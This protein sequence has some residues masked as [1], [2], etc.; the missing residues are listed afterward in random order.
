MAA[1]PSESFVWNF[2]APEGWEVVA[3]WGDGFGLRQKNGGLRVLVD[4][5]LKSD[6]LPWLHVSYSRRGWTPN[7]QDTMA[8]KEA[9]IGD[10][11]AYAVFPPRAHYVN[12]HEHCLHLWA[13]M[14]DDDG[15]VLPEFSGEVENIGRSI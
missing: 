13:R 14:G 8:V 6:G 1:L 7:H 12:I 5:E 10:R 2:H 9:F 11:Y 15:R 3:G 4:C